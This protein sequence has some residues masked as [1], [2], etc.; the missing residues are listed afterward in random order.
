M[1]RSPND[2]TTISDAGAGPLPAGDEP[3]P[4]RLGR[5]R[6]IARLSQGG[7]GVVY[8][9][10][11]DELRRQVAI[12]VPRRVYTIGDDDG[13]A[14]EA[15]ILARLDHPHIVP[16]YDV[17]R[18][19]DGRLLIVSKYIDGQAYSDVLRQGRP[20]HEAVTGLIATIADA[21]HH[22]HLNGLV[23][24]DIK[25]S[26]ILLDATGRPYLVDFGL[27][28]R[29]EDFGTGPRIAGTVFYMSPEQARN[30]GHRVDGRSDVF[31][32]GVVLYEALTSRRPFLGGTTEEI[33]DQIVSRD[34]RPLRQIDDTIPRELERICLKA[35]SK[36]ATQ[37]F[38]TAKDM[39][40]EL[41]QCLTGSVSDR[42]SST[43]R[44][45]PETVLAGPQPDSSR[46]DVSVVPK[47]LRSFDAA[48]ADFFPELVPG[49][50]DRTGLPESLAG[51]VRRITAVGPD[52]PFTVGLIY[53]PSGCGKSSFVKAGIL[54]RLPKFVEVIYVEAAPG[55]TE[56]R[57]LARLRRV[58]S[59]LPAA[60]GLGDAIAALRRGRAGDPGRKVLLVIDQF[61]QWL[62]ANPVESTTE[63]VGALR[64]CDGR[65]VQC[66]LLVRDD[67][68][69]ATTR[70]MRELEVPIVDGENAAAVDLFDA[71]HAR[72]VLTLLGRA[73]GT[74]P[75][76]TGELPGEQLKFVE[77]AVEGLTRETK[78][79]PVR[80]AVFA[81]MVKG[82]EWRPATIKAIGGIEGLGVTFL[83]ES[84]AAS[85]AP[86]GNR[87]HQAAARAVLKSLLPEMD[88]NLKGNMRSQAELLAASG[89]TDRP[90]D[91]EDLMQILHRE[92][93]LV[94]PTD[95]LGP[96]PGTGS[97]IGPPDGGQY[98]QLTHDYLVAALRDWLTRKQKETRR[99]RAELLLSERAQFYSSK[100]E[101]RNLPSFGEWLSIRRR[102]P[103]AGA[104]LP[105][106]TMLARA[107]R[108]Y[109]LRGTTVCGAVLLVG[110]LGVHIR[111]VVRANG[112]RNQV[113]SADLANMP[114]LVK[115]MDGFRWWLDPKLRD[116]LNTTIGSNPG[117]ELRLRLALLP[118]Y[119]DQAD[120]L[121]EHLFDEDPPA[122]RATM[123][124]L[125]EYA[126]R[127][128][129]KLTP[130]LA[131]GAD[132]NRRLRAAA[133]LAV[134]APD[135][136]DWNQLGKFVVRQLVTN[137][138]NLRYW[139][140]EFFPIRDKLL[141]P[142]ADLLD[143]PQTDDPTR[144]A[145]AGLYRDY[146]DKVTD[147]YGPIRRRLR[148]RQV[149]PD[150]P[151]ESKVVR[152]VRQA[153]LLSA[154]V[155]VSDDRTVWPL[156]VHSS[157][158]T[159]RSLLIERMGRGG[160]T[161]RQ[162]ETQLAN[163]STAT[164]ARR[165]I[166]LA[167]GELPD[168]NFSSTDR[169]RISDAL[170][171]LYRTDADPGAHGAADWVLR[172]WGFQDELHSSNETLRAAGPG[173]GMDWYVNKAGQTFS[174]V[175]GNFEI[176]VVDGKNRRRSNWSG[177][178]AVSS[179]EVTVG[180][181]RQFAQYDKNEEAL[182]DDSPVVNVSWNQAARYCN[183]LT[184]SESELGEA[185]CCYVPK[186]TD[187]PE[188][189]M[190]EVKNITS[191][192]GY[193]LPTATEFQV[194]CMAGSM[195]A[196]A[197]GDADQNLVGQYAVLFHN[198]IRNGPHRYPSPVGTKK[199]NDFGL[200]DMEGNV[201]ELSSDAFGNLAD[202]PDADTRIVVGSNFTSI[203][204]TSECTAKFVAARNNANS[205]ERGFRIVRSLE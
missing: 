14:V 154:L 165:A 112:L 163:E 64:Q 10:V 66:L 47:G 143:N 67:F 86:P 99:G 42:P 5:Y 92:L 6:V 56:T 37:R 55:H 121:L 141:D 75:A 98:Y 94:S 140:P 59:T 1:N 103:V 53:G 22:A 60:G 90:A 3:V 200:F 74:L 175:H 33:L 57:L 124:A 105:Q 45:Y 13:Y 162:F 24:R 72:K 39:A 83:E 134:W 192:R 127:L 173:K 182:T 136:G 104:T 100:P 199:P 178:I 183:F 23:H 179:R 115:E 131:E 82:R 89:Y 172:K 8:K 50:R 12:K 190:I 159:L 164:S 88:Q 4:E 156:L 7:F 135:E 169:K 54:P 49:P 145:A 20:T 155:A 170:L 161:P 34:P 146:T 18:T 9:A 188:G 106:K 65:N 113:A 117:L 195:A 27:A 38:T 189:N 2:A 44:P 91:F 70:L 71:R 87:V 181:Y 168:E 158:P 160:V 187:R 197:C 51:W 144:R 137:P 114:A 180:E 109:L 150:S 107:D 30:E 194:A 96:A 25:P 147:P 43:D 153:N 93:R 186:D 110:L 174:V 125:Q 41:R 46:H 84:F 61:E 78:V 193:R 80:L 167:L 205:K 129:H 184:R 138:F 52:D 123:P 21:L 68:W 73:H 118:S 119:P 133:C 128:R 29:E 149:E 116:D 77:Q 69:M 76:G 102:V 16:V 120:P 148:N 177:H 151:L 58:I 157:D 204:T 81:E 166:I 17:E 63:L 62:H 198:S 185:E 203:I 122:F 101:T 35:L 28:L 171:N 196:F 79:S 152:L 97:G 191:K 202:N 201:R 132:E 95:P 130:L 85:N 139:A 15:R 19:P 126:Y 40:E 176:W 11:D 32:L 111:G 26:N 31:S 108:H 36:P 142:L 48:D